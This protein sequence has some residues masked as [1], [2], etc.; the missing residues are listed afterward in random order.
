MSK[1]WQCICSKPANSSMNRTISLLLVFCRPGELIRWCKQVKGRFQ[2][3]TA[4][5]SSQ[6]QKRLYST[7]SYHDKL[8]FSRQNVIWYRSLFKILV[9]FWKWLPS[10]QCKMLPAV[11]KEVR[12]GSLLTLKQ[13]LTHDLEHSKSDVQKRKIWLFLLSSIS[14]YKTMTSCT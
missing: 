10:L 2:W 6:F 8:P 7:L 11:L 4:Y 14:S 3:H 9:P 5:L 13:P 1:T 12:N